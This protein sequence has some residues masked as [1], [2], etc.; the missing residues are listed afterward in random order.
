MDVWRLG[1]IG[2]P[3]GH[4]L[5]SC[6]QGELLAHMEPLSRTEMETPRPAAGHLF[7]SSWEHRGSVAWTEC[8][9]NHPG[10]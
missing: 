8:C 9:I 4:L 10:F 2:K 1:A 6:F 5:L 7:G 3:I